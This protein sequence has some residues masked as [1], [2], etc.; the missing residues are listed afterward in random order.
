MLRQTNKIASLIALCQRQHEA[1]GATLRSA[2]GIRF[3]WRVTSLMPSLFSTQATPV[4]RANLDSPFPSI[5][6]SYTMLF[7]SFS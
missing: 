5:L 1:I 2:E 6:H 3:D 7:Y 4:R